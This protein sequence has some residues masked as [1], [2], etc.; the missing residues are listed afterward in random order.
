MKGHM[1][2][3][4]FHPHTEY[5]GVRKSRDQSVKTE[6]IRLARQ[7]VIPKLTRIKEQEDGRVK[8]WAESHKGNTVASLIYSKDFPDEMEI[9]IG[10]LDGNF[11]VRGHKSI[12]DKLSFEEFKDKALNAIETHEDLAGSR[13]SRDVKTKLENRA[14]VGIR[15][16]TKEFKYEGMPLVIEIHSHHPFG[17]YLVEPYWN[18]YPLTENQL[19]VSNALGKERFDKFNDAK[20][21]VEKKFGLD[22][23]LDKKDSND[24]QT[25]EENIK[26]TDRRLPFDRK[27]WAL[28]EVDRD[29]MK[30]SESSEEFLKRIGKA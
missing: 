12:M 19:E 9:R 10:T 17:K 27:F 5:K 22:L 1:Q 25:W 14:S 15:A 18:T 3:G 13:K 23:E 4:K 21:F 8:Y 16:Y 2:D 6:G 26:Q 29:D 28:P 20:R 11:S 24:Y 30:I 7:R